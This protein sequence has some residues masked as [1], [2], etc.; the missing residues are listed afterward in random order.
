[1]KGGQI[2]PTAVEL[3]KRHC[4]VNIHTTIAQTL[5]KIFFKK[6]L[7]LFSPIQIINLFNGP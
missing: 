4:E 1:M 7:V 6:L 5:S 3:I 2:K